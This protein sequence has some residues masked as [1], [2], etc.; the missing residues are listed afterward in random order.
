MSVPLPDT[1]G[2]ARSWCGRRFQTL[3]TFPQS[4]VWL[5]FGLAGLVNTGFGYAVFAVLVLAGIW[6]GAA[7][8]GTMAAAAA[9]NFQTSRRLVFRSNGRVLRFVLV[10][11]VV[12]AINWATLRLLQWSGLADLEAQALLTLP[13]A[14]VSFVGQQRFVFGAA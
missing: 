5:R 8:I 4:R 14:A 9:F 6:P 3:L 13:V 7:L 11:V 12:L 2:T 1:P 10:Y